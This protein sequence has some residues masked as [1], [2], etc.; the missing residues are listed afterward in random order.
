MFIYV[1]VL[2]IN[3]IIQYNICY[4]KTNLLKYN[5]IINNKQNNQKITY[6]I[7]L[8]LCYKNYFSLISR[9]FGMKPKVL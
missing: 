6:T 5:N 8:P 7:A 2:A 1:N 3:Y 4:F 9:V